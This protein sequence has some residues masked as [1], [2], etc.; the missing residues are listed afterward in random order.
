M[1]R[2]GSSWTFS[3][4]EGNW[5]V[6]ASLQS[7]VLVV[8]RNRINVCLVN[9]MQQSFT[10]LETLRHSRISLNLCVC[11]ALFHMQCANIV[12]YHNQMFRGSECHAPLTDFAACDVSMG[13]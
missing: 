13:Y 3:Y 8:V 2:I 7:L 11:Q 9:M 4:F 1:V 10:T 12:K 6:R 5:I